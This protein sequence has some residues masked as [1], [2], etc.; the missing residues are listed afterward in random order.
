MSLL[1]PHTYE[2]LVKSKKK[3]IKTVLLK[4]DDFIGVLKSCTGVDLSEPEYCE[5]VDILV[6]LL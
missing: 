2:Q 3:E 4:K 5:I 1:S 6:H